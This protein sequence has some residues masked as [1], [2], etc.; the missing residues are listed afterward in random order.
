[1]S[2]FTFDIAIVGG[3][4]IGAS[5][6][7]ELSR[8]GFTNIVLLDHGRKHSSATANSGGM[9]RV[10][11]E[12][13]NHLELA[14]A[15]F[16]RLRLLQKEG[17][18]AD[19][20]E[21]NGSLYFFHEDRFSRYKENLQQM[22][23]AQIP[24]E[25]ISYGQGRERFPHFQW[26]IQ[27]RAVFEPWGTHLD[28]LQFVEQLLT[29]GIA[30]GCTVVDNF[31]V[32]RVCHH[33]DQYRIFSDTAAVTAKILILAGG[34][35]L[36]P[37]LEEMGVSLPLKSKTL[38]RVLV[39]KCDSD[40]QMENYFD[41]ETLEFGCLSAGADFTLSSLESRRLIGKH[42]NNNIRQQKARDCYAP[43]RIGYLGLVPGRERMIIATGWGG[44]AFKFAL[45]IGR[46]VAEI[47]A[48][49]F[50]DRR[51]SYASI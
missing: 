39:E 4:C 48:Y 6:F 47:V 27:D 7:Q 49:K 43:N 23:A 41:R 45:E 24:F 50:P 32:L 25:I 35:G 51:A 16:S 30:A 2:H 38:H 37:R 33:I 26:K 11:H 3:G 9:L 28:P 44:T 10:F 20:P 17:L 5:I 36:L 34:A 22:S 21:P 40:L 15:N 14:M 31:E 46:R 29:R 13:K 18:F 19:A 12:Q 42:W 8:S 1:M